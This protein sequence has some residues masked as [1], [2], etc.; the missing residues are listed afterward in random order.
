MYL[1][2][3]FPD[4]ETAAAAI[5]ALRGRG[6]H[7]A[8]MDLFSTTPIELAPG[9]LDRP[10]RMSLAAVAGA[11][12]LCLLTVGF[13]YFT[14]HHY[15][16]VTGGMPLFSFWATGVVFFEMTMLGAIAT[17][18][19]MFLWESGLLRRRAIGPVPTVEPG[20]IWL[21]VDCQTPQVAEAGECLYHAGATK[22]ERLK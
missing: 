1:T 12:A 10:S 17:T 13:V 15:P 20:S 5:T 9:V 18:F 21:R 8:A 11:V 16:L 19:L 14:Q 4:A 6:L 2:A 3:E 7:P 22:V